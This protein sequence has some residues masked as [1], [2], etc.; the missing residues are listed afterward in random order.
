M[1]VPVGRAAELRK[2]ADGSMEVI[3]S[4][5]AFPGRGGARGRWVARAVQSCIDDLARRSGPMGR[6][7]Q[8]LRDAERDGREAELSADELDALEAFSACAVEAIERSKARAPV[9]AAVGAGLPMIGG[10]LLAFA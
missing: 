8:E 2:L 5:L 7:V 10:L 6:L 3:R 4:S 9:D 1:R